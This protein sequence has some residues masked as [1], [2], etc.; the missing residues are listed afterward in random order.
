MGRL[1]ETGNGVEKDY[2]KAFIYYM[3]AAEVDEPDAQER[4][5]Y[6]FH[7]GLGTLRSSEQAKFWEARANRSRKRH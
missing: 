7:K 2:D 1:Y 6:L 5:A 4:L 3:L